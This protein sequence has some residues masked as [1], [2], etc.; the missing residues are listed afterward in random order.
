MIYAQKLAIEHGMPL[1]VCFTLPAAFRFAT[2]RQ[3]GFMLKGLEKLEKVIE[4]LM[5]LCSSVK[6]FVSIFITVY[7]VHNLG[8]VSS[9]LT[10]F[11]F[12]LLVFH[13]HVCQCPFF[14]YH[15]DKSSI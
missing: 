10:V 5:L 7:M 9:F 11:Y 12:C 8:F 2:I 14:V 6:M 1:H 13:S 15:S 4:K 3:Y